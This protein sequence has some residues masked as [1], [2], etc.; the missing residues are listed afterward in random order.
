MDIPL[1]SILI[2]KIIEKILELLLK[3]ATKS[4]L[5]RLTKSGKLYYWIEKLGS[6]K[7][8][9]KLEAIVK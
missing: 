2:E 6:E 4:R 3:I 1:G 7:E 9:E 8:D 5:L